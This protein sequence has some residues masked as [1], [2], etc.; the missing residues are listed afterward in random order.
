MLHTEE[1]VRAGIRV[2]DGARV[3]ELP[4]GDRLTPSAQDWLRQENIRICS[5]QEAPPV[6]TTLSGGTLTGKPEHMTH[7]YG[8]VLVPKDHPRIAFRGMVDTLEAEILLCQ[9][10]AAQEK[11]TDLVRNLQEILDFVRNL[12]RAD[13]L[14]EKIAGVRLCGLDAPALRERSH[15]PEKYYGQPHFMPSCED[16]AAL[17]QLNRVRTLVRQTELSCYRAFSDRDGAVT[18]EDMILA[19]NRLSSLCWILMIRLRANQL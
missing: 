2:K 16:S 9:K 12:I 3:Y 14:G 6:Y 11:R 7:L 19:L 8:N 4:Q 10:A 5:P 15:H 13:V 18:R 1:T 17:L